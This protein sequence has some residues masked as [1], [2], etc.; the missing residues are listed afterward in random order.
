MEVV[1]SATVGLFAYDEAGALIA[2]L[3]PAGDDG[4]W[5][6]RCWGGL[7]AANLRRATG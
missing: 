1:T 2:V 5:R 3:R 6:R 4:R 7:A